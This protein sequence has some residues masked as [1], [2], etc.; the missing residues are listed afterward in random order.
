[1]SKDAAFV[2]SSTKKFQLI[3]TMVKIS[4]VHPHPVFFSSWTC[5]KTKFGSQA[6]FPPP[7]PICL[8]E[9]KEL[10]VEDAEAQIPESLLDDGEQR[11]I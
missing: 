5:R 6:A 7:F 8:P 4:S 2:F 3:F 10:Q 9:A 1:M 11:T